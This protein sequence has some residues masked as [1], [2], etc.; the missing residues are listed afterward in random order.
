VPGARDTGKSRPERNAPLTDAEQKRAGDLALAG[1]RS[2]VVA[3]SGGPDSM[4]AMLLVARWCKTVVPPPQVIVATVDHGLRSG[5]ADEARWVG[6]QASRLGLAHTTL[7]WE[8]AKPATGK[9]VAARNARYALLVGLAASLPPPAAIVLA[10]HLDDQAETFLMRLARG[11]GVDGLSAMLPV[12]DLGPS[13]IVAVRPFLEIEKA[14][15]VA[16][17]QA[18]G[19]GWCDDPSN[20]DT[21]FE[22]VR[23]RQALSVAGDLGLTPRSIAE[24]ARRLGRARAALDRSTQDFID[25]AVDCHMGAYASLPADAYDAAPAEIRLRLVQRL[26]ARFGGAGE[27]ARTTRQEALAERLAAGEEV[28]STLGGC[29]FRRTADAVVALREPGR[30]GLPRLDLAPGQHAVW[31]GRFR[32]SAG[33]NAPHGLTVAAATPDALAEFLAG[34]SVPAR[35]GRGI[36]G[37]TLKARLTLPAFWQGSRLVAVPWLGSRVPG[38]KPP[39]LDP[40]ELS[41]D[42]IHL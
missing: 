1:F 10:H 33:A 4:A 14:R 2:L 20:A 35:K 18:H 28:T 25:R 26:A 32:V 24:S 16:T 36:G 29:Q 8:G 9:Q 41:A 39:S 19:M 17:L 13:G 3:V 27:P 40:R 21:Q 12:R 31:D 15:L 30:R 6:Q 37:L 23:L 38:L 22:R 11:S 34:S 42:F 7:K 5:S